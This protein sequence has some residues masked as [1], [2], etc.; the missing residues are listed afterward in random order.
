MPAY[1]KYHSFAGIRLGLGLGL[2]R[3]RLYTFQARSHTVA[4][5]GIRRGRKVVLS[6]LKNCV[7]V[8]T[9][10]LYA[11]HTLGIY[12]LNTQELR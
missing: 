10:G 1:E 12:T 11:K 3:H 6:I 8:R 7:R 2:V 9:Y 4:Y 5:A